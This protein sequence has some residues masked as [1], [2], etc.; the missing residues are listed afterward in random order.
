MQ[1]PILKDQELVP[2]E[3]WAIPVLLGGEAKFLY[4]LA[5]NVQYLHAART[6]RVSGTAGVMV[7]IT[8][9]GEMIRPFIPK[10]GDKALDAEALRVVSMMLNDWIP[11]C[12]D[13]KATNCLVLLCVNF[14]F[15]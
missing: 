12:L 10:E 15:G 7:T 2:L 9:E 11:L 14:R 8:K 13:G 6:K 1:S 4:F 3:T 5:N